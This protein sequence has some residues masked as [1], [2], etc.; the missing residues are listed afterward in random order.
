M[1]TRDR[2]ILK[3]MIRDAR[4]DLNTNLDMVKRVALKGRLDGLREAQSRLNA[5]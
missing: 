1:N 4:H 3:M 5:D 2:T